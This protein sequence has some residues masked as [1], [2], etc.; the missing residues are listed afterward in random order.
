MAKFIF[1][2]GSEGQPFYGGWTE[3]QAD[4][5][6]L[7]EAAFRIFHPSKDGFLNCCSVYTEDE[8]KRTRMA[9]PKGNLGHF[10]HEKIDLRS[11]KVICLKHLGRDSWN[12]P[13]Y[14]QEDGTLW[15]DVDPRE[16]REPKLCSSVNN[17]FDGESCDPIYIMKRFKD[18]EI[19]LLPRR[20]TWENPIKN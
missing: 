1:T 14:E 18:A 2:Y 12:R 8:F 17:L 15:K 10:C 19:R 13:V 4:D 3:V 9:G 11:T 6:E 20:D 5:M 7:A 16:G